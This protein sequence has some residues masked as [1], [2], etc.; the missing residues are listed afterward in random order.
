MNV[1][2]TVVFRRHDEWVQECVEKLVLSKREMGFPTSFSYEA[3]RLI[4]SGL[5]NSLDGADLDAL[6]LKGVSDGDSSTS[7]KTVC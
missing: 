4:K 1:R 2:E 3:V 7:R 6:I 5:L